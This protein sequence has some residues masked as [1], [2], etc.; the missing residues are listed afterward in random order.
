MSPGRAE[1]SHVPPPHP[2][3]QALTGKDSSNL[4]RRSVILIGLPGETTKSVTRLWL[5]P[6]LTSYVDIPE[7]DILYSRELPDEA[8]TAVWV[9]TEAKLTYGSTRSHEVQAGFLGGGITS[10]HLARTRA[11]QGARPA[12][13]QVHYHPSWCVYCLPSIEWCPIRDD[14]EEHDK[15]VMF[16][17]QHGI[18]PPNV[19]QDFACHSAGGCP[20]PPPPPQSVARLCSGSWLCW[21]VPSNLGLGTCA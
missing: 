17:S 6:E 7:N 14:L 20:P 21:Y 4:P 18:C 15:P 19:S 11:V 13:S 3:V 1:G 12:L 5:D 9:A 2:L 10:S 16:L 8:G